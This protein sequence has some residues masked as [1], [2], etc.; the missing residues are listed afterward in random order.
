[1]FPIVSHILIDAVDRAYADASGIQAIN[2]K[3]RNYPR[4]F[5]DS[6]DNGLL[7]VNRPFVPQSSVIMKLPSPLAIWSDSR[8]ERGSTSSSA[9]HNGALSIRTGRVNRLGANEL[10][11]FPYGS[12]IQTE[13]V[14]QGL[15]C[16]RSG[17]ILCIYPLERFPE[18][19]VIP[20][21]ARYR[22]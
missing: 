4:H 11:R 3:P 14:A 2:A 13:R 10:Q 21:A 18:F 12:R 1:M 19:R 6:K 16:K 5:V 7:V 22:A 15:V 8:S 17:R 9:S 20:C